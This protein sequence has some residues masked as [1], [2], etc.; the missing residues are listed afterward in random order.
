MTKI[1]KHLVENA[2][3]LSTHN[4]TKLKQI[5]SC[6][7]C[8]NYIEKDTIKEWIDQGQTA[9]CSFCGID[10]VLPG[11]IDADTLEA[12]MVEWFTAINTEEFDKD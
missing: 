7:F 1:N 9:L 2:N 5:N 3:K 10:S 8:L 12:C 6:Y 11:E 4:K